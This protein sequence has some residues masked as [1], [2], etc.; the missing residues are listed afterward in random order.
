MPPTSPD[1]WG[2]R[3]RYLKVV[4]AYLPAID[5]W[6]AGRPNHLQDTEAVQERERLRLKD[7]ARERVAWKGGLLHNHNAQPATAKQRR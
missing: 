2:T 6:R 7:M 5:E 3:A 1:C 4:Q